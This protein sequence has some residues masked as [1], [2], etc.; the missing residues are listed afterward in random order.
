MFWA[1]NGRFRH[2][3]ADC[4]LSRL[5]TKSATLEPVDMATEGQF[6]EAIRYLDSEIAGCVRRGGRGVDF[7][8]IRPGECVIDTPIFSTL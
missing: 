3:V 4:L 5:D 8:M 1:K 6:T 2:D 7:S